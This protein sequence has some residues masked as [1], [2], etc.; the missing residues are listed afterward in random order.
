[1]IQETLDWNSHCNIRELSG[2]L[3]V[4]ATPELQR[5][6]IRLLEQLRQTRSIQIT[7][8]ARFLQHVD[9]P[10]ALA[11]VFNDNDVAIVS[12]AQADSMLRAVQSQPK[13]GILSAP[14]LMLF[15]GEN[16]LLRVGSDIP[17]VAD[18]TAVQQA[19]GGTSY[20]PKTKTFEEGTK[21]DCTATLAGDGRNITL[22]LRPTLS[23]LIKMEP[24]PWPS[25]PARQEMFVPTP[26]TSPASMD[27][28]I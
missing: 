24:K 7:V 25:A 22:R 13:S 20:E 15:N 3:I 23:R 9:L 19:N 14:R 11:G 1:L 6:L 5:Q 18:F 21:L 12:D 4:T 2:Q 17:Y 26:I 27:Q 10:D 8:E 16:A 28:T